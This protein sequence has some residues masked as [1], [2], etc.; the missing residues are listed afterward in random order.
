[1]AFDY[2]EIKKIE[3]RTIEILKDFSVLKP[4]VP[5]KDIALKLG[6]KVVPYE[7]DD[8]VS[9]ILVINN[10]HGTIGYNPKNS[11]QRRRFTIAH[12]LGHFILH[13]NS[14]NEVFIDKDFIVKYRSDKQY[15]PVE[16]K[17]EQAANSFAASLLMPKE[18]IQNEL[19]KSIYKDLGEAEFIERLAKTFDVSVPAMSFRSANL[20]VF[21]W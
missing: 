9:G 1:M 4:P 15:T 5:V 11:K 13:N 16:V 20:D 19:S 18:L 2:K 14:A 8:D 7:F 12:E 10:N 21:N 17:Q 3:Q 6:L